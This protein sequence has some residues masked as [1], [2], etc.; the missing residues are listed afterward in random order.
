M[1]TYDTSA[2]SHWS[3]ADARSSVR[4]RYIAAR[5]LAGLAAVRSRRWTGSHASSQQESG[6]TRPNVYSCMAKP[7]IWRR[8]PSVRRLPHD[9]YPDCSLCRARCWSYMPAP[10]SM[11]S[12]LPFIGI[13]VHRLCAMNS[14]LQRAEPMCSYLSRFESTHFLQRSVSRLFCGHCGACSSDAR[15]T[16]PSPST[17]HVK[18]AQI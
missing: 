4:T 6:H 16:T 10:W 14:T 8:R 17:C 18:T 13:S 2:L 11:L 5:W 7:L 15:G 3:E 12:W 9:K 1:S